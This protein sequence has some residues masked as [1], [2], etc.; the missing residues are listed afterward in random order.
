MHMT[1]TDSRQSIPGG[2][3]SFSLVAQEIITVLFA[4]YSYQQ[5]D[6][7]TATFYLAMAGLLLVGSGY[8]QYF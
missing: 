4:L 1:E 6:M 3:L 5:G 7:S 2:F 8:S